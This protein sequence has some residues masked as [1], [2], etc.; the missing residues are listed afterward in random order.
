MKEQLKALLALAEIDAEIHG[1]KEI[2]SARP[3][4]VEPARAQWRERES[5]CA[6]LEEE[7]KRLRKAGDMVEPSI[8]DR[9]QRIAKAQIQLNTAKNN[10]EFQVLREQVARLTEELGAKEEEGLETLGRIEVLQADVAEARRECGDTRKELEETEKEVA[11]E[12]A[13][14]D[15]RLEALA[16]RRCEAQAGVERKCLDQYN[17]VLERHRNRVVVAVENGTCQGCFMSVTPQMEN[18]LL[19]G[20]DIVL[21]RSCQRIL[22][23]QEH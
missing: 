5:R 13:E 20:Q 8:R 19:L 18:M 2:R 15:A 11:E 14:I 3:R 12:V 16:G 23:M 21:C 7:L 17:R 4:Q 1:L 9:E 10:A 6:Q 22:Y